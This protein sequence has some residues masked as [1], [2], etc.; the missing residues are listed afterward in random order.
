MATDSMQDPAHPNAGSEAKLDPVMRI[1]FFDGECALC[2]GSVNFLIKRD[3]H[4]RLKFAPLQGST[5][6]ELLPDHDQQLNSIVVYD[7][8][9][10]WRRSSAIVRI[11]WSLPYPWPVLGT[12]LWFV[13][14]PLRDFGYG[15]VARSR[16]RLF[17]K[18][19]TCRM[20]TAEDRGRILD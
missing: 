1:V 9:H 16:Y 5:A 6:G 11:L 20:P 14:K 17:G 19:E 8:A 18:H 15:L 3:R 2:N 4:F 13:P 10:C 12:L 7:G